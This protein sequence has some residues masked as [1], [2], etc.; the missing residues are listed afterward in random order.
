ME[1]KLRTLT[2]LWTG[3]VDQNCL[4]VKETGIVGS[5]RWW[6][7]ALVRAYDG[8]ACDP[9]DSTCDGK[10]HC[11]ACELF[12]CTGWSRKFRIEIKSNLKPIPRLGVR[13][14]EK[15][16]I[17]D[18]PKFLSRYVSGLFGE[19]DIRIIPIRSLKKNE[20]HNLYKILQL[21]QGYGAL[22]AKT[23]QG[24]GVVSIEKLNGFEHVSVTSNKLKKS[25]EITNL[26]NLAD[27]FFSKFRLEFKNSIAS[28]IDR[29]LLWSTERDTG[30]WKDFWS[31]YGFLPIAFHA[32]DAIRPVIRSRKRRH[33]V[34]GERGKG[35]KVF[36]SHG[37]RIDESIV[38]IRMFGYSLEKREVNTLRQEFQNK[39]PQY[40]S[41]DSMRPLKIEVKETE[42]KTGMELL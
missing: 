28:V 9:T 24:N 4:R 19:L 34:F 20:S 39:L 35:S 37:Y 30:T 38:E 41:R 3:D 27:F 32:R 8:Q 16:M 40:I 36:V 25:P 2:P 26:P 31:N 15:R 5:L 13:T 6:Y 11:D 29:Q 14:R 10:N 1:V 22:G 18:R 21:V 7:E 17:K 42:F 23:S 12:G 33:E